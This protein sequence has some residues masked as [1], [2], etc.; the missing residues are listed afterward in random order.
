MVMITS[1]T[2]TAAAYQIKTTSTGN[3]VRWP[4]S[5][6]S[7]KVDA[8]ASENEASAIRAGFDAWSRVAKIDLTYDGTTAR[9]DS[10]YDPRL[11][12]ANEN[13]VRFERSKWE[14]DR[15]TLAVTFTLYETASGKIISSDVILNAVNY[16][17]TTSG[18]TGAED[19]Q[20]VVAHEAGHF[21]G[22]SH[23]NVADATMFPSASHGETNKRSLESDDEAG[24][25]ALYG[26]RTEVAT[27]GLANDPSASVA[28]TLPT[29]PGDE[30]TPPVDTAPDSP[31]ANPPPPSD[32]AAGC[33]G[34]T[35]ATGASVASPIGIVFMVAA[36]LIFSQRRRFSFRGGER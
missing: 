8:T 36:A 19:V 16:R 17:W 23:S 14:A 9:A 6:A 26:E 31:A 27:A 20:N 28:A 22:L 4:D 12:A 11:G 34:A 5:S 32:G 25:A 18:E 1:V 13:V 33:G 24:A 29:A 3:T 30:G 35:I 2:S 15:S 21:V 10:G 7:F